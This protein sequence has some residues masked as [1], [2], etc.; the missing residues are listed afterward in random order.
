MFVLLSYEKQIQKFMKRCKVCQKSPER[1]VVRK[2]ERIRKNVYKAL[3]TA[4][5]VPSCVASLVLHV[6]DKLPSFPSEAELIQIERYTSK[7]CCCPE[8]SSIERWQTAH[9]QL[10]KPD[11]KTRT[12]YISTAGHGNEGK[13][14]FRSRKQQLFMQ[15]EGIFKAPP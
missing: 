3:K 2:K 11:T 5:C 15:N 8:H 12:A 10:S 13:R 6:A 9:F 1:E 14:N 4:K 7:P